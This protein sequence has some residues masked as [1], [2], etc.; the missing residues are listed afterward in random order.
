MTVAKLAQKQR[1]QTH[2]LYPYF[3]SGLYFI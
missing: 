1:V 2:V 3:I